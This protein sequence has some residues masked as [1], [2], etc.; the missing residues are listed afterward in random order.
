M[1]DPQWPH[2]ELGFVLKIHFAV[3]L[4]GPVTAITPAGLAP[5][6][7]PWECD[8][9][10]YTPLAVPCSHSELEWSRYSPLTL[11]AAGDPLAA[12]PAPPGEWQPFC[13][14]LMVQGLREGEYDCILLRG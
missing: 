14:E 10:P 6:I 4:A 13:L 8:L 11:R 5:P 9:K 3:G 7:P 2:P 1:G 12:P